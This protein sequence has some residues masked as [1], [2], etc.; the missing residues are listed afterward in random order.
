MRQYQE[1]RIEVGY[2]REAKQI[3]DEIDIE[4]AR[5]FREGW[6]VEDS[7]LDATLEYIDI[8]YYK[9]IDSEGRELSP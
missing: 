3:F 6:T 4:M 2:D 1:L 8:I 7:I 9:D 5:L